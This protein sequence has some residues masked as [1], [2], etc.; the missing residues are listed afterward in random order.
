MEH[1]LV[2]LIDDVDLLGTYWNKKFGLFPKAAPPDGLIDEHAI[3]AQLDAGLLRWPYFTLMR[4][5]NQP[6]IGDFTR[7]RNVLGQRVGSFADPERVRSHL[8]AGATMKFSQLEDW[9]LPIRTLMRALE[10]RIAAELKAYVFYTPCDNTGMLPHRDGSHVLALQLAGAKEWTIYDAADQIDARPGLNVDADSRSHTFVM[11]PGDVLYLPH[12]FPHVATARGGT[13]LHLTFTITE[14]TPRDLAGALMATFEQ[15]GV[16]PALP[17][18]DRAAA[19]AKALL[20]HLD[21]AD[22]DVL[23]GTAVERMRNRTIR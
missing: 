9:H 11:E 8:A 12:G 3:Q 18:E 21:S 20:N 2:R 23:V 15:P 19:V 13:S 10:T 7:S 1:P 5:G 17:L 22:P 16:D 6:A 14:P 4:E